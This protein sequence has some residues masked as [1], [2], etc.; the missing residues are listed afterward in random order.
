M[1][2]FVAAFLVSAMVLFA[3]F[4][5]AQSTN[6]R[7]SGSVAD[8]SGALI[9]GVTVTSTNTGT[10]VVSTTVTNEVGVYNFPSLLPGEYKVSASLPGFQ[11]QTFTGVKLGNA[12]QIR[13]NF[14][15]KVTSVSTA[16]RAEEKTN[17]ARNRNDRPACVCVNPVATSIRRY[18]SRCCRANVTTPTAAVQASPIATPSS[19]TPVPCWS[20]RFCRNST[21][22]KPSR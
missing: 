10:G 6:A 3:G 16:S 17:W 2:T 1:R 21:T 18:G 7:V 19:T 12:D 8:G 4:A 22:S 20:L 9:P 13:L 15:L 14:V 11:T 5:S